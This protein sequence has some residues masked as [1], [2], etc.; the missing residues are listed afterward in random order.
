M[1]WL[2]F[3]C[4]VQVD[5]GDLCA[6]VVINEVMTASD[7][8]QIPD[9]DSTSDWF[10]LRNTGASMADLGGHRLVG[11]TNDDSAFTLPE[12]FHIPDP[13]GIAL[14][15]AG[16]YEDPDSPTPIVGFDFNGDGDSLELRAGDLDAEIECDSV[17]I[18][19]QHHGFSWQRDPEADADSASPWCD[20]QEPTPGAVNTE[21]LCEGTDAC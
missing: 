16:T 11:H 2:L 4:T 9:E 18:P 3:A 17:F 12:G 20:S 6:S 5:V 8:Y 13:G 15:I 19:D 10:E 14:F 21:C 1:P 7:N